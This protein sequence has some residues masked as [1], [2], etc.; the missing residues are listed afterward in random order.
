MSRSGS[1]FLNLMCMS[2]DDSFADMQM[3][4]QREVLAATFTHKKIVLL[5]TN[6]YCFAA[7]LPIFRRGGMTMETG[8]TRCSWRWSKYSITRFCKEAETNRKS[9]MER[10]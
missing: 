3:L 6:K 5:H 1:R 10:C 7:D 8:S 2:P 4:K 9:K